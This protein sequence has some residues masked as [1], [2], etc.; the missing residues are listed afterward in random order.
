M[1]NKSVVSPGLNTHLNPR[2]ICKDSGLVFN[3]FMRYICVNYT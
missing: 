2:F 1:G 3:S